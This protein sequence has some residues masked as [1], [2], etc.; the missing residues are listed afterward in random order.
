MKK[1]FTVGAELK[2]DEEAMKDEKRPFYAAAVA[3]VMS[4]LERSIAESQQK[5]SVRK[6]KKKDK[7]RR[8]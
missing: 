3:A 4:E 6:K 2:V 7:K 5:R 1:H 8:H